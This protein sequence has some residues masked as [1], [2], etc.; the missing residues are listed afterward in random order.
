MNKEL[1]VPRACPACKSLLPIPITAEDVGKKK[2]CECPKCHKKIVVAVPKTWASKFAADLTIVEGITEKSL[3]IETVCNDMTD[4]QSFA[5]TAEYYTI[6]RKNNTGL[7][8]RPDVQL[9]STDM[10]MSRI[11]AAIKKRGKLGF[12]LKDLGSKNG[13]FL[14]EERLEADEE[15]Y[16]Y[17]G[18]TI[19]IGQTELRVSITEE[20]NDLMEIGA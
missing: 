13:T 4:Y 3:L 20:G 5:I 18:D 7:E 14:N 10:K 15:I 12:T 9:V 16:L 2:H 8:Y 11:H 17:D 1:K 19:R 6:G